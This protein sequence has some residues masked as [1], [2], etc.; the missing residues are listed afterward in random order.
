MPQDDPAFYNDAGDRLSDEMID[1]IKA[2]RAE[3]IMESRLDDQPGGR[4]EVQ[5]RVIAGTASRAE[6]QGLE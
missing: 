1:I 6:Q 2:D 5:Q 4:N 3:R